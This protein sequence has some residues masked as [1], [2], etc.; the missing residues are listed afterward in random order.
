MV[1][2]PEE[3]FSLLKDSLRA[4]SL[5]TW[6]RAAT[7]VLLDPDPALDLPADERYLAG[8]RGLKR[9]YSSTLTRGVAQGFA[10]LGTMGEATVLDDQN[11]LSD[12]TSVPCETF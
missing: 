9:R 4:G 2:S 5:Q 7:D 12:M 10:L 1:A 11:T 3:A 8:I 6:L